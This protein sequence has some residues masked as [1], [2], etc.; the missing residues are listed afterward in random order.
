MK[1]KTY[2]VVFLSVYV[3][4]SLPAILGIGY[5]IDWVPEATLLQKFNGYL[6]EGLLNNYVI[7]IVVALLVAGVVGLVISKRRQTS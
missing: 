6:V 1:I 7:K 3:L 4:L 2:L 5:V